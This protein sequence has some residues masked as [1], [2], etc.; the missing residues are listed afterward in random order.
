MSMFTPR[1]LKYASASR[2]WCTILSVTACEPRSSK[3]RPA[4]G[5]LAAL[6]FNSPA[7][8]P[9]L[10]PPADFAAARRAGLDA[11]SREARLQR[12]RVPDSRRP[13][14]E[15]FDLT[16]QLP[17]HQSP[18]SLPFQWPGSSNAVGWD[19]TR[20]RM[21]RSCGCTVPATEPCRPHSDCSPNHGSD[22]RSD[23]QP[24]HRKLP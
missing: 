23:H 16:H 9:S 20:K 11:I 22:A 10:M 24:L 3:A 7:A 6:G 17:G 1:K 8:S 14:A 13:D 2:A 15:A 19:A 21:G 18:A 12:G 4:A 5:F